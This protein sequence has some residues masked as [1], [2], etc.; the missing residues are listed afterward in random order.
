M[1]YYTIGHYLQGNMYG[2]EVGQLGIKSSDITND[3]WDYI[4][5]G[6]DYKSGKVP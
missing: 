3:F 4:F 2:S 5:L 1:A 6:K